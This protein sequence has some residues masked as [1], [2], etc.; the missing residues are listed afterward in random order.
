MLDPQPT[1][2]AL[3]SGVLKTNRG[4]GEL[5]NGFLAVRTWLCAIIAV[6]TETETGPKTEPVR[7]DGSQKVRYVQTGQTALQSYAQGRLERYRLNHDLPWTV[8]SLIPD[9]Q[10][11]ERRMKL[12]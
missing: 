3:I 9:L 4:L 12:P 7:Y 8:A 1:V 6:E 11:T 10:W 5:Q 2:Q